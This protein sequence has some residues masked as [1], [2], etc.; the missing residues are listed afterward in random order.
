M[1]QDKIKKLD[2]RA[3]CREKLSIWYGSR[4]NYEHGVKELIANAAD[5]LRNNKQEHP[6]ILVEVKNEDIV[7]VSDNGRGIP[8][9][10]DTDGVH[11]YKLLFEELFAGTKYDITES[12][13]TGTNGVGTT[14]L[15]YTSEVFDVVSNRNGYAYNIH[16]ENGGL[17]STFSKEKLKDESHGTKITV[18]LDKN[19]YTKT[20]FKKDSIRETVKHFAVSALGIKFIFNWNDEDSKTFLYED[21]NEYFDEVIKNDTTSGIFT[22]GDVDFSHDVDVLDKENDVAQERN[23]YN[24]IFTTTP[25]VIQESY[26]N[27]TYLQEG[28][29]I[30]QGILDSIRLYLNKYC[31]D[32]KLFP[33]NTTAFNKDD[34]ESS[35]AFIAI[36]ESNNVEFSNQTKLSTNK[37]I[38][39]N[40]AK[41]YINNLLQ[42]S[43][44]EQPKNFKKMVDH[45]L[46]V[47]KHNSQNE[48]ARK[49]LKKKLTEKVD[50]IGNKIEK[51]IDCEEHGLK[52][53]LYITEGLSA[54][55]SI[56]DSRDDNFQAAYPLRGKLINTLKA[57]HDKVFK[58]Q[59]IVDLVKIIGTGIEYNRKDS[60]F[61]I[62]KL[63]YGK[64]IITTDADP[65]GAQI[66]TLILVFI[67]KF[68]PQLLFNGYVYV[69]KT[70][71]YALK[72][73]DDTT[74]YF[75]SEDEKNKNIGKYKNKKYVMNRLKGLGE[76]DAHIMHQT[77]MN[78]KT[79]NLVRLTVDDAKE[80]E[81]MLLK[82]MDTDIAPRKE[83]I[84]NQLKDYI[85]LSE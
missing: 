62:N 80:A 56:I 4:D 44:V 38:Y 8:I 82:W 1:A 19:I 37:K 48:R 5:E 22:L 29:S 10:G 2:D 15:N 70:P 21:Y 47:Q 79:R 54:N 66:A 18:K 55:G 85:D 39:A 36:V 35:I 78:P 63:R 75:V 9:E 20:K 13:T 59:E 14:V 26:L 67:Y 53:E 50:G 42:V 84:T 81:E 30:N 60:D 16:Y 83:L 33:K 74:V 52:A 7:S 25:E 32:N 27:M 77:A 23:K 46:E 3:K 65:D 57:G 68:M 73:D 58:N 45:I 41:E 71:L 34:V 17:N 72:F 24:I 69:A 28:G 76:V 64:I 61:D 40:D 11:N 51:L 6:T 31:R 43:E 49:K 12:V